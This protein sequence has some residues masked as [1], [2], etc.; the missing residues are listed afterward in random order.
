[1]SISQLR[2]SLASAAISVTPQVQNVF[3]A[4]I[5]WGATADGYA[6]DWTG[7]NTQSKIGRCIAR[8]W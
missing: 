3:V 8:Y 1:L 4:V 5:A 6:K 7:T 2:L